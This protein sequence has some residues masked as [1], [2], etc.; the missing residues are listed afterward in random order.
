MVSTSMEAA[1]LL[2]LL[3]PLLGA[4]L[5]SVLPKNSDGHR[6]GNIASLSVLLSFITAI[7]LFIT[8]GGF[9]Q[10]VEVLL[11]EWFHIGN[12]SIPMQFN[13][14]ALSGL[15]V[16]IITG[17]GF[18]IH[19]YSKG[20]MAGDAGI[21]RFF[22]YLNLFIFFMLMLVMAS[23]YVLMFVGW[24]G[25]GLCSYLL[26]GFWYQKEAFSK[27]ANKAFIM[28]RIGDLGFLLGVMLMGNYFGSLNFT[29]IFP[30]ITASPNEDLMTAI[31]LLL[32]IGAIGKSAQLPL[33]TWLP[34][35]MA[36]PTP[37][38]ALIHAA[39]M[40]TAG[41]Y[42]I[43]RSSLIY[44]QAPVALDIILYTGLATALIAAVIAVYQFDIKK[45]LAYSTVSQL[46]LM[47]AALG[48]GG[49]NAAVFHVLTHAAFKALLFLG[50]GSVIHG[51]EGEQ[52]LR[53][54][55]GLKK[56]M[57]ATYA[58]FLIGTL[59]ISGIPPFAG[60][61]SKDQILMTLFE[62]TGYLSFGIALLVSVLTAFYMFRLLFL[63]FF[64]KSRNEGHAHESPSNM[65]A[66]LVILAGL[67]I[68]LGFIGLPHLFG[69]PIGV[70]HLLDVYLA[71]TI[72]MVSP[73]LPVSQELLL[74][75]VTLTLV[76]LMIYL[77]YRKY[78]NIAEDKNMVAPVDLPQR[79]AF[80]KF[81]LDEV[82][83]V[84]VT[85]NLN[86]FSGFVHKWIDEGVFSNSLSFTGR[87]VRELGL[88]ARKLQTGNVGSYFF[89]M[90]IAMCVILVYF[91]IQ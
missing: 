68:V 35:A 31:G 62:K 82:Y 70:D 63:C 71:G 39:T 19:W 88:V 6:S 10:P 22:I 18:L 69:H 75:G 20:Y 61:F 2:I 42:L 28:N 1:L 65:T 91:I 25:V 43:A 24:E 32:F 77:A 9:K 5:N 14:D 30:H 57:P 37:V 29:D 78:A 80:H 8:H 83:D 16:L 21:K 11:F 40:V 73:H 23:N 36:G 56:A 3:F 44:I 55:G 26:I 66:P 47:F 12:L 84:V 59:A 4:T 38:S 79:I 49:F 17:I 76:A 46:G 27:A 53:K 51:L 52:D 67:S 72:Q 86:M 64:G 33:F 50:A 45:V 89:A 13:L 54:M 81:Y 41:I 34:D 7:V 90:V 58:T 48:A 85:R 15:F 60:F 74:M 87:S